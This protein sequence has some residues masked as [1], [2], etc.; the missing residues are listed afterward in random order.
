M[1]ILRV[2]FSAHYTRLDRVAFDRL[3]SEA[4]SYTALLDDD[5]G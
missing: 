4:A 5:R 1:D 2:L 3:F